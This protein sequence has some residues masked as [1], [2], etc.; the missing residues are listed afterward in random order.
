MGPIEKKMQEKLTTALNPAELNIQNISAQH[1]G[2]AGDNG[3]GESHFEV[4]IVSSKFTGL[5]RVAA[6]RMVYEI[7]SDEL[8]G[9]I[10][11]LSLT[12]KPL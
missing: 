12:L 8:K 5:S 9:D 3:T 2:H 10:H 1:K 6:Q 7:L 11:A 4:E